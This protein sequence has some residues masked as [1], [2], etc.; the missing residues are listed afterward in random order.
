MMGTRLE[1]RI[2]GFAQP[3]SGVDDP[4][5]TSTPAHPQRTA[6]CAGESSSP[7]IVIRRA[8][9]AD[10]TAI[11]ALVRSERLNPNGLHWPNFWLAAG[12][13]GPKAS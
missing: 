8:I 2:Q 6:A 12:A 7:A 11:R 13:E 10:Q 4:V 5:S 3:S 9:E 1:Y